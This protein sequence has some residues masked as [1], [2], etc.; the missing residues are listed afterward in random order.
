MN[1]KIYLIVALVGMLFMSA[2]NDDKFIAGSPVIGLNT[3]QADAYFGDSLAFVIKASDVDVLLST[4]KAQLYYGEEKVS[5]TVIRTKVSGQDYTGKIFV[6]FLPEIANGHATLRYIL[7]N[8][9][10]TTSEKVVEIALTRPDF[11]YLTLVTADGEYKMERTDTYQYSATEKFPLEVKG[12]IKTPKMGDNGNELTFGW[13]SGEIQ[14]GV[15]S[16]I[17]FTSATSGKYSISFNTYSYVASPFVKLLLNG[18]EMEVVDNENYRLDLT[19]TQGQTLTFDGVPGYDDWWI[20][21]DYFK[22]NDDGTLKFLPISGSYRVIAN[23]KYKYFIV[24]SLKDGAL[25]TLQNDGTGAIW[26]IGDGLGKPSVAAKEVGWTT[27]N[28]LCMSQLEAKKYQITLVAGSTVKS[29]NINFKFF[30]Q[31]DWGGEFDGASLTSS[32]DLVGVGDGSTHD[33]GNLYLHDGKKLTAGHIY[34]FL[35]D[36]TGGIDKA[37]LTVT[38]EGE[39]PI[40]IKN[41]TFGGEKMSSDD[42]AIYTATL[43]L[44]QNQTIAVS[45]INDLGDWWIN[46]DY[47]K[48]EDGGSL[49]FIPVSGDY[50]V[51]ANTVIKSFSIVRMNG[52]EEATLSDDGHGAIWM[53][54]WGVGSPSLDNQFGWTPGAAYCMP[55]V[56]PKIYRFTAVAGPEQGSSLGQRIRFDYVS[57]KFFFQDGWGGEFSGDNALT[58]AAGAADYITNTGNIELASD[59]QLQEDATY[60]ITVDLTA[61]NSKGVI[62]FVKQ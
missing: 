7:Q 43:S 12:Y 5:E 10:S 32:S 30:Y 44:S 20:D 17:T 31:Q 45:G 9:N 3:E 33:N 47:F 11:P 62:S 37:T 36:V 19:L 59:V 23:T 22:K 42:G 4:L 8:I 14:Q 24:Q 53:M 41:I 54:G 56:A 25:A 60:V 40:E 52:S 61:G 38:D 51:V 6:P 39:Q 26:I 2:C 13:N 15:T 28:G 49:S 27:G 35:V 16:D 58:L 48:V 50:R 46:P 34:K 57:C 1:N 18:S 21:R 55:E 29:D